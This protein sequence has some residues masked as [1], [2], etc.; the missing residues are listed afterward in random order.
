[1]RRLALALDHPIGLSSRVGKGSIFTVS[2]PIGEASA[3]TAAPAAER[4]APIF[5]AG[6]GGAKVLLIDNDPA[7]LAAMEALLTRWGCDVAVAQ[8]GA[9]ALDRIRALGGAPDAVVADLH[10][11]HGERGADAVAAIRRFVQRLVPAIIVTADHSEAASEAAARG[12]LEVLRKPVRPAELR[13]LLSYLL[14]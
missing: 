14:G 11:D 4:A 1:V 6:L 10:L 13:S 9:E 8:S 3:A 7:V 12:G 2:L 5:C